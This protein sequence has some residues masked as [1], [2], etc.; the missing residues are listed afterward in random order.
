MSTTDDVES[1]PTAAPITLAERTFV[2]PLARLLALDY[3]GLRQGLFL[4]TLAA[5]VLSL[6]SMLNSVDDHFADPWRGPARVLLWSLVTAQPLLVLL[7]RRAANAAYLTHIVLCSGAVYFLAATASLDAM[8]VLP[9]AML[10][11]TVL[12][13][14]AM[15]LLRPGVYLGYSVVITGVNVA[16]TLLAMRAAATPQ[17]AA[18][19]RSVVLISVLLWPLT[20]STSLLIAHH[21]GELRRAKAHLQ[22]ANAAL[23]AEVQRRARIIEE[24]QRKLFTASK[25]ESLGTLAGGIA[26]DFNNLLTGIRGNAELLSIDVGRDHAVR[27]HVDSII[28]SADSG[29]ALTRQLLG[30]ARQGRVEILPT[31]PNDLAGRCVAVLRRTCKDVVFD[32]DLAPSLPPVEVDRDQMQQVLFNL[33]TN[34]SQAVENGGHV[35]VRTSR[36]DVGTDRAGDLGI[37]PGPYV[38]IVVEDDGVGMDEATRQRVFEPFFTTKPMGRGTGLGLASAFGIV[39]LHRGHIEVTSAP[40]EGSTFTVLLRASDAVID[41]DTASADDDL[42]TGGE[43]VL[44]VDDE[45]D[46]RLVASRM[47]EQLGYEVVAVRD[48]ASAIEHLDGEGGEDVD[49]VVLDLVMPEMGGEAVFGQIRSRRPDL[50]VL[51]VSG[52]SADQRAAELLEQPGV[53][54]IQK[55]FRLATLADQVRSLLDPT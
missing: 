42:V 4:M 9:S 49:L 11:I 44:L 32:T 19:L 3:E 50:P 35:V 30:F 38:A 10:H 43:V 51:L 7:S 22:R 41:P 17:D 36:V 20:V 16:M 46:V 18:I 55:P 27:T 28:Q 29:A 21:I 34:A 31:D 25:M 1:A 24:Q 5:N 6:A 45:D 40:G 33:L 2:G 12:L 13:L 52:Y 39:Q 48:G 53:G 23:E 8:E 14:V 54:F 15:L 26:H 47:L 37:D